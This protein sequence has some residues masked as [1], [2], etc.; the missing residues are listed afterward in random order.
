MSYLVRIKE[1]FGLERK[2]QEK[3]EIRE[4]AKEAVDTEQELA[5]VN[6]EAEKKIITAEQKAHM[7][8]AEVHKEL[9][10]NQV[11]RFL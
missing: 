10:R 6:L 3:F 7:L 11:Q 8:K 5:L 2:T 9:Y 4:K 1:L